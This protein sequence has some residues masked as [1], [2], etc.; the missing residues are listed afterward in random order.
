MDS[1]NFTWS[2][3]EYFVPFNG[4]INQL[5]SWFISHTREPK[6]K[7]IGRD[8][9]SFIKN[10]PLGLQSLIIK[11]DRMNFVCFH[12]VPLHITTRKSP[13]ILFSNRSVKTYVPSCIDHTP[14][15]DGIIQKTQMKTISA[16]TRNDIKS[17]LA[18]TF[19]LRCTFFFN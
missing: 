12:M 7:C 19:F 4:M 18:L 17:Y 8:F 11:I 9:Q 1:K 6:H 15:L 10:N 13:S 14:L 16:L 2:I 3:L 5:I